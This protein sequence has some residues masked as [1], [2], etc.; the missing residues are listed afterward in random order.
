MI[1]FRVTVRYKKANTEYSFF[2]PVKDKAGDEEP[3]LIPA[4]PAPRK[5]D[6]LVEVRT[7]VEKQL[8]NDFEVVRV[9]EV[10]GT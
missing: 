1:Q 6:S 8:G 3:L 5:V 10:W 7:E 2:W 9:E 4:D